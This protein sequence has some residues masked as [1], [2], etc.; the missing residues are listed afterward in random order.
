[1]MYWTGAGAVVGMLMGGENAG[2]ASGLASVGLEGLLPARCD[3]DII[4]HL[5]AA[6]MHCLQ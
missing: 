2:K 5:S 6:D 3:C 1:M 4:L